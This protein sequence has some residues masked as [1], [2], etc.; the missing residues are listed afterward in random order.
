MRHAALNSVAWSMFSIALLTF[1]ACLS[2]V[3]YTMK[4]SS[5][6]VIADV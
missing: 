2:A 3:L 5:T 6:K 4:F 1:G